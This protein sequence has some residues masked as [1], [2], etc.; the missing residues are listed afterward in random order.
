MLTH[1]V[2]AAQCRLVDQ[3]VH[4]RGKPRRVAAGVLQHDMLKRCEVCQLFVL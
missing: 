3:L 2:S 4:V 1:R